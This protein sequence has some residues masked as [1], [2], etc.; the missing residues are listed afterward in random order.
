[1]KTAEQLKFRQRHLRWQASALITLLSLFASAGPAAAQS[2][3]RDHPTPMTSNKIK[4]DGVGKKI[5][6]FYSFVGGP[7]AIKITFDIRAREGAT[8]V[9]LELFDAGGDKILYQYS[10]ATTQKERVIKNLTLQA[11]QPILIRLA[12]IPARAN[13]C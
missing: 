6:Y 5:E 8:V 10:N 1:M 9:D 12:L 11:K 4:G 13:T 7:G 2:E 3:E